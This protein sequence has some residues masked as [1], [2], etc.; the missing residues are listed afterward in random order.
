MFVLPSLLNFLEPCERTQCQFTF[1][2][3]NNAI[4][5]F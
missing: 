2:A 4:G 5:V 1:V 3:Y